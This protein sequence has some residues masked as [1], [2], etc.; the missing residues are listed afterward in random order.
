MVLATPVQSQQVELVQKIDL[1]PNEIKLE[2]VG[3]YLS[4]SRRALLI[5]KTKNLEGYVFGQGSEPVDKESSEWKKW[6]TTNSVVMAWLLKSLVPMIAA[7][8][9]ALSTA[10]EVW[11]TLS[12]LY[13][14]REMSC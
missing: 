10:E 11:S 12:N 2:G 4:W 8:V 3:N 7:S 13:S 6:S 1:M 9:E 14:G 5:L